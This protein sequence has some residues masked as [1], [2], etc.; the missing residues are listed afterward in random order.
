[1]DLR[2]CAPTNK[3]GSCGRSNELERGNVHELHATASRSGMRLRCGVRTSLCP[4][5]FQTM[6]WMRLVVGLLHSSYLLDIVVEHHIWIGVRLRA[7]RPHQKF[8]RPD[9]AKATAEFQIPIETI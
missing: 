7:V 4:V 1:M 3:I 2:R 6:R 8:A 5:R 9:V